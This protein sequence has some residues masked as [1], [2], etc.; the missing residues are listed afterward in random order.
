MRL[1]K[2]ISI[3]GFSA[4]GK[5]ALVTKLYNLLKKNYKVLFID[6]FNYIKKIIDIDLILYDY[7]IVDDIYF[8]DKSIIDKIYN[9][10]AIIIE[11]RH[12]NR[13][14][15]DI[16]Y[17]YK[18]IYIISDQHIYGTDIFEIDYCSMH[19]NININNVYLNHIQKL[20]SIKI[21]KLLK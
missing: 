8:L 11:T 5:T 15:V 2:N 20:R 19:Y 3:I 16:K 17:N 7:I 6:G 21:D 18:N 13:F 9:S 14:G 10:K 12:R 1:D 4:I